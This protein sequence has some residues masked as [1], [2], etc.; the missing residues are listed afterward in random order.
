MCNSIAECFDQSDEENCVETCQADEFK[1]QNGEKCVHN[2]EI[3]NGETDCSD[4]SDEENC[5]QS[6]CIGFWCRD[7]SRCISEY[8]TCDGNSNCIDG[9]DEEN[10]DEL[11]CN[12]FF[13]QSKECIDNSQQ[14]NGEQDCLDGSDEKDC[15]TCKNGAIIK[16]NW[17]C[18]GIESCYDNS[19]EEF[20]NKT[21]SFGNNLESFPIESEETGIAT[22]K[23][24]SICYIIFVFTGVELCPRT[25]NY[26]YR[27]GTKCCEC[28]VEWSDPTCSC[29]SQPCPGQSCEDCKI[30]LCYFEI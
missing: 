3:C 8:L 16:P 27:N 21:N 9:S 1:C 29:L 6:T 7:D 22:I 24:D 10:C 15:F 12:G 19:E 23:N 5:T 14:C 4:G 25:H 11:T 18:D 2:D 20:C 26:A 17:V 30:T 28:D 13:C